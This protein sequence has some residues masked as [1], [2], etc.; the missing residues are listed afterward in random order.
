MC[1]PTRR[2]SLSSLAEMGPGVGHPW[3]H[4]V[5]LLSAVAWGAT[6]QWNWASGLPGVWGHSLSL[7]GSSTGKKTQCDPTIYLVWRWGQEDI[8]HTK[9]SERLGDKG[10]PS[11]RAHPRALGCSIRHAKSKP[12]KH[13]MI[14][15]SAYATWF[16]N[17][18]L[19]G[20]DPSFSSF[21]KNKQLKTG[22]QCEKNCTIQFKM[23]IELI[24]NSL[25]S[26]FSNITK[27]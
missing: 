11:A 14:T 15:P 12:V 9:R 7:A 26:H 21:K 20:M 23:V 6:S 25:C 2:D 24:F 4:W 8:A 22:F 13:G 10:P 17:K 18:E 16:L 3:G 27:T 19:S 1:L 5:A